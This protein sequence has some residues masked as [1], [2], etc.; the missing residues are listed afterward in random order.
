MSL[1]SWRRLSSLQRMVIGL[2]LFATLIIAIFVLPGILN[3]DNLLS[4]DPDIKKVHSDTDKLF[5]DLH[6][7]QN[8]EQLGDKL[9]SLKQKAMY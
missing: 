7:I 8:V 1:Q 5:G 4:S 6:Q 9:D 2:L 3:K